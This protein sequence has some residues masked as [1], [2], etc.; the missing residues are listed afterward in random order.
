MAL[1]PPAPAPAP[2]TEHLIRKVF[3]QWQL[4][5]VTDLELGTSIIDIHRS[6]CE[7][8]LGCLE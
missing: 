2:T 6:R 5:Q 7:G 3:L 4:G 1:T 8:C